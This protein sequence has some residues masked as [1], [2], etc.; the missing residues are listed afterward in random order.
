[1]LFSLIVMVMFILSFPQLTRGEEVAN[2]EGQV[3]I[4]FENDY[5]P[6]DPPIEQP[7]P[8]TEQP[9]P[10]VEQPAP[11]AEQPVPPIEPKPTPPSGGS[12]FLPQTG[13]TSSLALSLM[14]ILLFGSVGMVFYQKNK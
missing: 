5:T 10:P 11:P 13:E 9:D 12:S 4:Y 7:D 1:M 2:M 3:G 14:G 6:I 8:P